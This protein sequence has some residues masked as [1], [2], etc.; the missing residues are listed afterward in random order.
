MSFLRD[1]D[2]REILRLIANSKE[3]GFKVN[4]PYKHE[5]GIGE[6]DRSYRLFDKVYLVGGMNVHVEMELGKKLGSEG[7]ET[8]YI[9]TPKENEKYEKKAGKTPIRADFSGPEHV[10]GPL[11]DNPDDN[12]LTT[13]RVKTVLAEYTE[14]DLKKFDSP[15][16]IGFVE[17]LIKTFGVETSFF[18]DG[19]VDPPGYIESTQREMVFSK[20]VKVDGI[21][22][23][24][25]I[26]KAVFSVHAAG[27]VLRDALKGR[28]DDLVEKYL[29]SSQ[30]YKNFQRMEEMR[31]KL[32]KNLDSRSG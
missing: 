28:T 26:S 5:M 18:S 30:I 3:I 21:E 22:S 9:V 31:K 24:N 19:Y 25:E 8:K 23:V 4:D 29:I 11:V 1:S 2:V 20:V 6:S 16:W 32:N 27:S 13:A 7:K 17:E 15:D 12:D 10:E 14:L